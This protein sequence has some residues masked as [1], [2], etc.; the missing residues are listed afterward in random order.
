MKWTRHALIPCL[1]VLAGVAR[2]AS[3]PSEQQSRFRYFVPYIRQHDLPVNLGPTGAWGYVARDWIVVKGTAP[4]SPADKLLLPCDLLT[5]AA[6][7]PFGEDGDPRVA[8][9]NAVT[10]AEARG[11]TLTLSILR[12]G[13]AKTVTIPLRVVGAY[14]PT[15]PAECRKS[16]R[17]LDEAC[18]FLA[19]NAHRR[20]IETGNVRRTMNALLLL[21]SGKIE[22]LDI[23]RRAAYR[24][25]DDPLTGGYTGWSRSYAGI[26][27][28]EYYLATGDPTVLPKLDYLGKAT[29]EGQMLCGSWGHRMPWGAYGAVNQIGLACFLSLV[30]IEECGVD[31][32]DAAMKRSADFFAKYAGKGWVPYGDHVPWRGTSGNGKNGIAAV[33]YALLD[34]HRYEVDEF[35][36]STAA[37]H[38]YREVGHTGA[39]FSFAWG[40]LGAAFAPKQ[41]FRVFLD[42]QAW[43]YDLARTHDG[44][45]VCQPN[46]ENLSGRTPGTY[47][48]WGAD[49][50]TGAMALFYALPG[51][52]LR[53][54]GAPPGVFALKPS[55]AV[56]PAAALFRQKKWRELA[57]WLKRATADAKGLREAYE[58][59]EQDVAL[60]LK[61]VEANL[62]KGDVLT[63]SEQLAAV[64]RLLGEER[65][66]MAELAKT[67]GT[68]AVQQEIEIGKDYY[69][70]LGSHLLDRRA[71]GR[72]SSVAQRSKGYYGKAAAKALADAPPLPAPPRW[73]ML[74]PASTG[75]P[76]SWRVLALKADADAPK[77]WTRVEFDD[78]EWQAAA[79]KGKGVQW[80]GAR[81]L[82]RGRFRL[83]KVDASQLALTLNGPPET[84]VCL[85]GHRLTTM[86]QTPKRPDDLVPLHA[87]APEL[88]RK[89]ENVIAVYVPKG[90][91]LDLGLRGATA[92]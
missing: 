89:G 70:A 30:L 37:S 26:L 78:E 7:K 43:Y 5:G 23:V 1:I 15:W 86:I 48:R 49:W 82:L 83:D 55:A 31:V 8:L 79:T 17:I 38:A 27:L 6:G 3:P 40:P 12:D 75:E 39:Y 62:G 63:A 60:T 4:G 47:T 33:A 16:E 20:V 35:A 69:R 67:L 81:A 74:P 42:K 50:T 54:L 52:R 72:M 64:K 32:D 9:G 18:R 88:L 45:M 11:G 71:R 44:G 91:G 90:R 56:A 29:A 46:P 87:K 85:N 41:S 65:L 58:R 10:R 21:A 84:V 14:A 36:K 77:G 2:G 73:T 53:I 24:V 68:E 13:A 80:K 66:K 61:A 59:M 34:G 51:R 28:T 92:K 22:H 19:E 57:A 25:L 76:L